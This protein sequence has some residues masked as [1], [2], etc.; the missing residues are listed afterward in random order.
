MGDIQPINKRNSRPLSSNLVVKMKLLTKASLDFF[1]SIS[2]RVHLKTLRYLISK[3]SQQRKK[4]LGTLNAYQTET[5]PSQQHKIAQ[6]VT[7]ISADEV[8]FEESEQDSIQAIKW[9]N[10]NQ[11]RDI[12]NHTN[13]FLN[14]LEDNERKFLAFNRYNIGRLKNHRLV[15]VIAS[16]LASIQITFDKMRSTR[17]RFSGQTN[18]LTEQKN[19]ETLPSKPR[20]AAQNRNNG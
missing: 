1:E 7:H 14:E 3:M 18:A 9:Y 17:L 13:T 19:P 5:A 6:D 4:L 20:D 8:F 11:D 10:R 12:N 2:E 16:N 15:S